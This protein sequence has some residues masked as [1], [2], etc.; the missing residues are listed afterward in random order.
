[1]NRPSPMNPNAAVAAALAPE[2]GVYAAESH[3]WN[4]AIQTPQTNA[5]FFGLKAAL[6]GW[7]HAAP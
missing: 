7:C 4:C 5:R 2:R 1:M 6:R 3:E